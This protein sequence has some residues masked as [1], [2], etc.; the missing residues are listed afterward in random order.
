MWTVY[1]LECNDG[2]YY[3][4][5]TENLDKRINKHNAGKGARYTKLKRLVRLVY[6]ENCFSKVQAIK[7]EIEIKK[8]SHRNKE[9]LVRFGKRVSLATEN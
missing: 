3:T 1:I 8:L 9:Y 6:R 4:G 2:T 5:L 7:R